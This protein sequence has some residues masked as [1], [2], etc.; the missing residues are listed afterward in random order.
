MWP[1]GYVSGHPKTRWDHEHGVSWEV[2]LH[3]NLARALPRIAAA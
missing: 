3:Q 1:R 2:I